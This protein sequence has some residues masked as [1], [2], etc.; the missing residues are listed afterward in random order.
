M[1]YFV[2]PTTQVVRD[3]I[4]ARADLGIIA[5]P[6]SVRV[7]QWVP[8]EW[9]ADNG[10]FGKTEFNQ[11]RWL[12]F[13]ETYRNRP[14]CLFAVAPDVV[15]DHQATLARSLPW[16]PHL[17]EL[18]YPAAFVAQDGATAATMPW[19]DFDVVFLGG[20]T[21]FK[22]SDTARDIVGEAV[23]RGKHAHMGRVNS[24]RRLMLAHQWGCQ[25]VDGT[26]LVYGPSVNLPRLLG[27][28]SDLPPAPAP[29]R[30]TTPTTVG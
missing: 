7:A 30:L 11:D 17:R 20:T 1:I 12:E 13:L 22:L 5:T 4:A 25:S 26:Y 3:A 8:T 9:I 18:G 29:P 6:R 14:G 23:A 21:D 28:L 10:C 27:W 19:D 16:M 24:K 15:G 2:N